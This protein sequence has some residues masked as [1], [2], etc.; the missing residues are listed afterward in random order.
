[1][2]MPFNFNF[3]F[4]KRNQQYLMMIDVDHNLKQI[5]LYSV[6]KSEKKKVMA[7]YSKLLGLIHPDYSIQV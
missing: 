4:L 6:P 2:N 7:Q 3:N 5:H 1:M